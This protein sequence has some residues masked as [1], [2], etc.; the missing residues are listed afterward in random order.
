MTTDA[1]RFLEIVHEYALVHYNVNTCLGRISVTNSVKLTTCSVS[2]APANSSG[3]DA[4]AAVNKPTTTMG[5]LVLPN[6]CT[7]NF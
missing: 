1:V 7:T 5:I 2:L 3:E 6:S 4:G